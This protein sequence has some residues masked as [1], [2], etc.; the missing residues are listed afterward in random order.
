[1]RRAYMLAGDELAAWVPNSLY[2]WLNHSILFLGS[3]YA[4]GARL[5]NV[6]FF[7]LSLMVLYGIASLF[8]SHDKSAL[9]AFTVGV[10]PVGVYT[11]VVMPETMFL[12]AFLCLAFVFV[13]HINDQ[14]VFA[15]FLSGVVLG[16]ASLVSRMV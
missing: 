5:L 15:G 16:A 14:P 3:N 12:C 13:R 8:V 10:G 7:V 6:L 2:L 1:M 11:A 9:V 4:M